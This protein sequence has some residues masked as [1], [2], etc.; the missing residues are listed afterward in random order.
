MC[1]VYDKEKSR[2]KVASKLP[3]LFIIISG[4]I[5]LFFQKRFESRKF[6]R[7]TYFFELNARI[8]PVVCPFFIF[9][10]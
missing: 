4:L 6:L 5:R 9:N 3:A 10:P 7:H 8:V 2:S 1:V